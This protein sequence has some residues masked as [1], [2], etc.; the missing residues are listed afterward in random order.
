MDALEN[1]V[2]ALYI[3]DFEKHWDALLS[4]IALVPLGSHESAVQLLYV[5][6]SPQSPM[7]DLLVAIAHEL[8]LPAPTAPA[9][10]TPETHLAAVVADPARAGDA[11]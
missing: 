6:S 8:T 11:S 5:L 7:R 3:T 2:V 9:P 4:D 1:A 10:Q